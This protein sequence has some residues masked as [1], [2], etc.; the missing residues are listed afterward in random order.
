MAI[1]KSYF[2]TYGWEI[3]TAYYKIEKC[4]RIDNNDLYEFVVYVYNNESARQ[5]NPDRPLA[6]NRFKKTIDTSLFDDNLSEEENI[7]TAG[8]NELKKLTK[9]FINE[10]IDV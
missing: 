5:K 6:T 9:S 2:S 8:Y 1:Q 4:N 3:A 7:K 10:S